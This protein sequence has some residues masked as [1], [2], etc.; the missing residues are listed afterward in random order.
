MVD[1]YSGWPSVYT[2]L[3]GAAALISALKTHFTTFGIPAELSAD[4]G[5]EYIAGQTQSF[6][7]TWGTK[8][9]QSSAY[10]PHSNTRAELAVKSMKRLLKDNTSPSGDLDTTKFHRALLTYRNTPDRDTL[11]SPAQ[12]VFGRS[13]RDFIPVLPQ[14]YK[15]REHALARIHAK[16]GHDQYRIR[17]DG[18]GWTILRNRRF[19]RPFTPFTQAYKQVHISPITPSQSSVSSPAI[20]QAQPSTDHT[21]TYTHPDQAEVHAGPPQQEADDMPV[22]V[23]QVDDLPVS[24]R[25]VIRDDG[26]AAEV[27][28]HAARTEVQAVPEHIEMDRRSGRQHQPNRMLAQCIL[29]PWGL[30]RPTQV[31]SKV[32]GG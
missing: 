28:D 9:R 32:R 22:S 11:L 16:Q 25:Q 1:R 19:L 31:G 29:S 24:V 17:M 30:S 3:S 8:F 4:G 23:R 5:K 18:S 12:V 26:N 27:D 7:K 10:F 15:P 13:I 6:L 2:G 21:V 20:T 14:K